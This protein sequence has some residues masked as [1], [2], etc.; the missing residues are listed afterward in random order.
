LIPLERA[1]AAIHATAIAGAYGD[2][3]VLISGG[4]DYHAIEEDINSGL[5][6]GWAFS[7]SAIAHVNISSDLAQSPFRIGVA[8]SSYNQENNLYFGRESQAKGTWKD[9]V[10]L[11]SSGSFLTNTTLRLWY[12]LEGSFYTTGNPNNDFASTSIDAVAIGSSSSLNPF[13]LSS[14]LTQGVNHNLLNPT[15]SFSPVLGVYEFE[16]DGYF[17]L[18][19]QNAG[20][21]TNALSASFEF[22]V[23]TNALASRDGRASMDALHTVSFSTVTLADGRSLQEA[24]LTMEYASLNEFATAGGEVPEPASL[25]IWSLGALGCAIVGYRRRKLA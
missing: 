24:G 11:H 23:V 17:D 7:S 6:N 18:T 2:G 14:S 20:P 9:E 22:S 10:T 16:G 21:P 25:A 15:V 4:D 13:G 12:H 3:G 8:A 1:E 19:F 5:S